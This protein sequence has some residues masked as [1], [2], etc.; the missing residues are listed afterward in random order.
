[1]I[2]ASRTPIGEPEVTIGLAVAAV[3]FGSTSAAE[4][5]VTTTKSLYALMVVAPPKASTFRK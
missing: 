1:L 2:W 5:V 3:S 4:A